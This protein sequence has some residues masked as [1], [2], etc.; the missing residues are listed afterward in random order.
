MQTTL[1]IIKPDA[2]QRCLMGRIISRFEEKGLQVIGAK[3]I[4][5]SQELAA[6]HYREHQGKKFYDSLLRFMTKSPVLVLAIRG[7]TAIEVC[8]N[9]IGATSG[10]KAA[11]GTIRGDLGMSATFNLVHGSDSLESAQRE[12]E[13]FFKPEEIIEYGRARDEWGYDLSTGAPE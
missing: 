6:Q 11:P 9:I 3:F 2:V 4:K 1:I 7:K 8:R 10:R 13:L 12:I 5:I